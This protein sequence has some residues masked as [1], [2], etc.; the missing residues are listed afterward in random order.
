MERHDGFGTRWFVGE[1]RAGAV[2]TL[3]VSATLAAP[4]AERRMRERAVRA[5]MVRVTPVVPV[6]RIERAG[7]DLRLV[8]QLPAGVR[9]PRVLSALERGEL[10]LPAAARLELIAVL[11]SRRGAL[12]RAAWRGRT[13]CHRA[14]ARHRDCRGHGA[15]DAR[16]AGVGARSA[17]AEP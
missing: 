1:E 5:G 10:G 2:E 3:E 7:S 12:A 9:L 11:R 8:T 4:E 15:S 14:A 17:A 6:D 16:G 13:R